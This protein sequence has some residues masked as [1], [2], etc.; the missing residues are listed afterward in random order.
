MRYLLICLVF[1]PIP[2]AHAVTVNG[3]AG[4]TADRTEVRV[5][6]IPVHDAIDATLRD[7]SGA[8]VMQAGR[9]AAVVDAHARGELPTR[10]HHQKASSTG[11]GPFD[12]VR[13][14]PVWFRQGNELRAAMREWRYAME[15]AEPVAERVVLD[16]ETGAELERRS[17]ILEHARHGFHVYAHPD[18]R[19]LLNPFG[20]TWPH[21]SGTPDGQ[22]P[23]TFAAQATITQS[24]AAVA[25]ADPWL[26]D[27][28]T[29]TDGNAV[30]VFFN[31]VVEADGTV[32]DFFGPRYGPGF[33]ADDGDFFAEADAGGN[34]VHAYDPA[35]TADEYYQWPPGFLDTPPGD[36][37]LPDPTDTALN[38]K[39]VQA[40]WSANW[41]H[42]FLYRAGFDEAA[43]N[44]Q[45]DNFGRGG[46]DGDPMIIHSGFLTT[47]I[48]VSP[49]GESPVMSLG[50]NDRSMSRRDASMDFSV[51][52]HEYGHHMI[53]RVANMPGGGTQQERALHEGIADFLSLLVG[54]SAGDDFSDAFPV[55]Q[56]YNLDYKHHPALPVVGVP[57]DSMYY[58]VR[59]Y[60]YSTSFARNPLQFVHLAV[61]PQMPFY[62]WKGRGPVLNEPHTAGEVFTAALFQCW[63]RVVRANP[64]ADFE[65][66]RMRMAKYLVA[67]LAMFPERATFIEAR[68]AILG[69][70]RAADAGDFAA[71]R[72]G[73]AA[74][75]MG[76][77]AGGPPRDSVNL[78]PTFN[79]FGDFDDKVSITGFY[80]EQVGGG[81]QLNVRVRNTGFVNA[82]FVSV[83][84]QPVVPTAVTFPQGAAT[85]LTTVDV[86]EEVWI[87]MPIALKRDALPKVA[88]DQNERRFAYRI[89]VTV[90]DAPATASSQFDASE[91]VAGPPPKTGGGGFGGWW[92][93]PA[94]LLARSRPAIRCAGR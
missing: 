57:A 47:F 53:A 10:G 62:D 9:G 50:I 54:V 94:V 73:F 5:D 43:G 78:Q 18:G 58:G 91:T 76:A 86:D 16:A 24:Q 55:G 88:A 27:A 8:V 56:W 93:L 74:R 67:G 26:P 1:F 72:G 15:G 41:L 21:A 32:H 70:M 38:A 60:P 29:T 84:V 33:Q 4:L 31:S 34:F 42:D 14:E 44:A 66:I 37:G 85:T 79:G 12:R 2:I 22:V 92:L 83:E 63:D 81:T 71:C 20:Q 11:S 52:A 90:P 89:V 77:G 36:P 23:T 82:R 13:S 19:P 35:N 3:P 46:I 69:V 48:A 65:T 28:A 75:G 7:A 68:N 64:A 49:E 80:T 59:R 61:M 87:R 6:G 25:I 39:I 51:L 45:Q 40:F 17:L 30:V